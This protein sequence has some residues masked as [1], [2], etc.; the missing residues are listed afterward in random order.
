MCFGCSKELSH[1]DDSFEYPQHMFWLR[2]KK[3]NFQLCPLVWRSDTI[4]VILDI[5]PFGCKTWFCYKRTTKAWSGQRP[6][7]SKWNKLLSI[8]SWIFSYQSVLTCVLGAQKNCLIETFLLSTHNICFGWERRTYFQ[9]CPLIWRSDTIIVILDITPFGCKTWFGYIRTT[10]AM[11]KWPL[12]WSAQ[13]PC[14]RLFG[15][16]KS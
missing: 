14:S 8:K 12:E 6:C 4:I 13:H 5:T 2:N 15:K 1:W 10:K 11:T 3:T 16:Y 9:L 7:R